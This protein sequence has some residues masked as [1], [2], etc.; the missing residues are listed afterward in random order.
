MVTGPSGGDKAEA[1]Q[2]LLDRALIQYG[3]VFTKDRIWVLDRNFP[4]V[5]RIKKMTTVTRLLIRLRSSITLRRVSGFFPGGSWLADV[6]GSGETI[7]MRIIEYDVDVDGQDVPETF[8]LATDLL[9]WSAYPAAVLAA[10]YKWR[11]DG[12]ETAL[13]E[14]KSAIRGAGPSTG[15]IFRSGTPEMIRAEHAAWITACELVRAVIRAAARQA[16]PARKGR[17]AGQSVHPRE[18]SFTAARRA[19]IT[20]ARDDTATASLPAAA[21]CDRRDA[22]LHELGRRWITTGRDR[23]RDHKTKAGQAFPAAGRSITTRKAPARITIC[24]P[25]AA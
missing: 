1:E 18:I 14:D 4:G 21:R 6:S 5:A 25:L 2:Q 15:P 23:H 10:A 13:R 12:S 22:V 17:R 24:G 7:R 20:A 9:D 16:V 19:A 8:C 3:H 11:W